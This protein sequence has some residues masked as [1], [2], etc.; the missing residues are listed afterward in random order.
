MLQ[1]VPYDGCMTN[2][3]PQKETLLVS[4]GPDE[5]IEKPELAKRLRVST[6]TV[7]VWM[8]E[9][10]VPFLKISKSVRFRWGDVLDHLQRQCRIN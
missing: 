3:D 7:D 2:S 4:L 6:R 1:R 10:R 5:I 8:R 9:G